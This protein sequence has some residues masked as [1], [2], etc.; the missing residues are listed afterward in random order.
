MFAKIYF[1]FHENI[2]AK[3]TKIT[4]TFAKVFAKL[5][6][7]QFVAKHY[8]SWPIIAGI[9]TKKPLSINTQET[10]NRT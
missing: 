8:T 10:V 7:F 9:W 1:R 6:N 3:Y 2:L 5:Q 4:K